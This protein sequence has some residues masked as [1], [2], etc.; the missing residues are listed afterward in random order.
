MSI[1]L[2]FALIGLTVLF[3]VMIGTTVKAIHNQMRDEAQE[4]FSDER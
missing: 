2:V 1:E 4:G 3:G